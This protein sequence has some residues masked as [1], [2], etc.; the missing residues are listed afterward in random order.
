VPEI[1]ARAG[2]V[3]GLALLV[4][5]PVALFYPALMNGD[6]LYMYGQAR[7]AGPVSDWHSAMLELFWRALL[8]LGLDVGAF[9]L[10]QSV[11]YVLSVAWLL[12]R[13]GVL[14]GFLALAV[15]VPTLAHVAG[16]TERRYQEQVLFDID[17]MN[18]SIM[19]D[20]DLLPPGMLTVPFGQAAAAMQAWPFGGRF[21]VV[22]LF[23]NDML[24]LTDDGGAVSVRRDAWLRA[25]L[26][27]P[28]T[29]LR[30]R[31]E[32]FLRFNCVR[33]ADGCGE[34]WHW[35]TGGI[36][37]PNPYG[38]VS[39]HVEPV[40]AFYHAIEGNVFYRP[41]FYVVLMAAILALACWRRRGMVGIFAAILLGFHASNAI[42]APG[43]TVRW[44]IPLGL[45]LAPLAVALCIPRSESRAT[46]PA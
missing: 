30:Y 16:L 28:L 40:F 7:D 12:A 11:L 39:K 20:E 29:Y 1:L 26:D 13:A 44:A 8:R 27:H 4:A 5:A 2:Y 31:A 15:A 41:W 18:L 24:S 33:R 9:A 38:L 21:T 43:A 42:L 22:P 23:L 36:D 34:T 6:S 25:I 35:Y 14:A 3:L 19:T 46:R 45:M 32:I 10:M 37:A 17:L